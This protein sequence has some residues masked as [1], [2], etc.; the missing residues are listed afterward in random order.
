MVTFNFPFMKKMPANS[1]L[2][3][4]FYPSENIEKNS[5][6]FGYRPRWIEHTFLSWW[7][8]ICILVDTSGTTKLFAGLL[9]Y[10]CLNP[11]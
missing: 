10:L 8:K 3:G 7:E 4:H 6:H 1:D 11:G 2:N 5:A 9:I